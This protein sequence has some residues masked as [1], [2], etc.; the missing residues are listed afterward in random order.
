MRFYSFFLFLCLV[1]SPVSAA[2]TNRIVIV[3]DQWAPFNGVPNSAF[4]GYMVDIARA[5]FEPQGID[6][7][8]RNVPWKRAIAGTMEGT[9]TAAIGASK[10]DGDGLIFPEEELAR[11]RLSFY[12]KKGSDWKFTGLESLKN[13]RL[14]VI[15]GYDYREWL[16][17]YIAENESDTQKVQVVVGDSPLA[18]NIKKLL[19]NRIDVVVG[20]GA[21]IRWTAK[22]LG[23]LNKIE[24][25]GQGEK[26]SY[27]YIAFS[28]ARNTSKKYAEAL[29][30]GVEK[31]RK[32]GTLDLILAK[33]GLRDWKGL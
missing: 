18:R 6:V 19:L 9:Y 15:G 29:D 22:G 3:A 30:V 24:M 28:P 23:A 11:N 17:R 21:A 5:V 32:D 33:Y 12:V 8:Y 25:A 1:V 14:G 20:N 13:V 10:T 7:V 26:V 31:L 27:C 4:E 16:C 2:E